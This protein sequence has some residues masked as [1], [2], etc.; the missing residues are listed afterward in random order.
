MD[1]PQEKLDFSRPPVGEVVLS[2]HFEQLN[3]LLTPYLG[4]IWQEFS[5][6]RFVHI[7]EQPPVRPAVERFPTKIGEIKTHIGN[8]PRGPRIW[9]IR[10]G[11][12][13]VIQTQRDRFTFNWRKSE[14]NP[15]YPGFSAILGDFEEFYKRFR[16]VLQKHRIGD[17]TPLQYELSY[18]DQLFS[19]DGWESLDDIGKI[20]NFFV[21]AQLPDSSWAQVEFVTLRTSFP[22]ED[23]HGRLHLAI[24]DSTRRS[25]QKQTLQ[26]SFILRGLPEAPEYEAMISW[27]KAARNQIRDKFSSLFTEDIQTQV[28]GRK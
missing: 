25:D 13:K 12:N 10:D 28:W 19:G 1:T 26:T 22:V 7:R 18:I 3:R 9:F 17:I 14:T 27:F 20:Y 8:A 2:V 4:E 11:D 23:L 16:Q 24:N 21:D 5:K 6:D 15:V